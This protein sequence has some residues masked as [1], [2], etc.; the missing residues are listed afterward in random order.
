MTRWKALS[1]D[2]IDG[3][4]GSARKP[5][6]L[7]SISQG[8]QR[9]NVLPKTDSSLTDTA[10]PTSIS[11]LCKLCADVERLRS[12]STYLGK[13]C[14]LLPRKSNHN[15][16]FRF[17]YAH[18]VFFFFRIYHF[19]MKWIFKDDPF[20]DVG[21]LTLNT[22]P[23]ELIRSNDYKIDTC[24]IYPPVQLFCGASTFSKFRF[25]VHY[26]YLKGAHEYNAHPHFS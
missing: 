16:L 7:S 17:C 25:N 24:C 10:K 15:N 12:W 8:Q 13:R 22:F 5:W 3:F 19:L 14:S 1:F 4:D 9:L 20:I 18:R 26:E 21:L 11:F 2:I 23:Y 6:H